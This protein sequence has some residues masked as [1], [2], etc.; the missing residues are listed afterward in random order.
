MIFQL[1]ISKDDRTPE[2]NACLERTYQ[3]AKILRDAG[4]ECEVTLYFVSKPEHQP[5][6]IYLKV[7]P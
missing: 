6:A 4:F 1:D 7:K 2:Q 3:A 5:A